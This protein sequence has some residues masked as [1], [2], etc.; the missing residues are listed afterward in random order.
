MR[1]LLSKATIPTFLHYGLTQCGDPRV[2]LHKR[3][4]KNKETCKGSKAQRNS[5]RYYVAHAPSESLCYSSPFFCAFLVWASKLFIASLCISFVTVQKYPHIGKGE[6]LIHFL[7]CSLF[8]YL[9]YDM[10]PSCDRVRWC[11]C[12]IAVSENT[13]LVT[14]ENNTWLFWIRKPLGCGRSQTLAHSLVFRS[15][16]EHTGQ[17]DSQHSVLWGTPQVGQGMIARR[18]I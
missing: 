11:L 8:K 1:F 6:L 9:Q 12:V 17:S 18:G 15:I 10:I 5:S 16:W 13:V 3:I 14:E 2:T 7:L 4:L